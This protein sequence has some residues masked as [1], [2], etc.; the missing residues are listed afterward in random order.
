VAQ[1]S[2]RASLGARFGTALVKDSIVVPVALKPGIGPVLQLSVRDDLRGPWIGDIT[3]DVTPASLKREESGTAFDAGSFTA[4]AL[5]FGLSRELPQGLTARLGLGGLIYS[6]DNTGV[7]QQGNGGIFPLVAL[8]GSFA[9]SFG[10]KQRLEV[11]LQYDVHRFM[12]PALRSTGFPNPRPVHR[13]A[14]VVSARLL[15]Q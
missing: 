10:A 5:T 1:V 2:L 3:V 8:G 12:T 4:T 7:F 14:L 13:L 9:P 6:T 11:G 15:G